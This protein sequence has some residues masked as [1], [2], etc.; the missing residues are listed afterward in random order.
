M[1]PPFLGFSPMGWPPLAGREEVVLGA[2]G[3]PTFG[4]S[5]G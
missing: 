4:A 3:T 5:L 1:S 2:L